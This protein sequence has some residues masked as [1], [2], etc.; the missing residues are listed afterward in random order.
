MT[1][2][3]LKDKVTGDKFYP[4]T[5]EDAVIDNNG[6]LLSSKLSNLQPLVISISENDTT[7]PSGTYASI[8]AALAA[9]REVFV[10][11]NDDLLTLP[12]VFSFPN[13][14]YVFSIGIAIE[15]SSSVYGAR[16]MA[17]DTV[18]VN[19]NNVAP[20]EHDH[21]NIANGGTLQT[22]DIAIANGDK[23]VVTDASDSNKIART[24][25]AFDGST[26]TKALSQKGTFETFYQKP[27][28]GIPE[29]HLA[30]AVQETLDNSAQKRKVVTG[31]VSTTANGDSMYMT[32][33]VFS[34]YPGETI[35]FT[36]TSNNHSTCLES[37]PL[38]AS[39]ATSNSGDVEWTNNT[40]DLVDVK[41]GCAS[42][43]HSY[44]VFTYCNGVP[45]D[46]LRTDVQASLSKADTAIQSIKTLN[47]K[48]LLGS[49]DLEVPI[50]LQEK[51]FSAFTA[52]A[53]NKDNSYVFF[54]NVVPT[55]NNFYDNWKIR[56]RLFVTT[57]ED[58]TQGV[59]ECE[60][61]SAGTN[62]V[63]TVNNRFYST[64]YLPI[65][66]HLLLW[67]STSA[68]YD[69]RATYPMK[70]GVRLLNA[71]NNTTLARTFK[72]QILETYNCTTSF[73]TNIET[74]GSVNDD[75]LY[76]SCSE[77][78]AS[79]LGTKMVGDTNYP[80]YYYYEYYQSYR[81]HSVDT[82]LYRYKFCGFDRSG[83]LIPISSTN[84]TSTMVEKIPSALG[85]DVSRGLVFY[86]SSAIITDPTVI[87]G[88]GTIHRH[89]SNQVIA[90]A[91]Y[92]FNTAISENCEIY[93][94][95]TY[96][97]GYFTL[98]DNAT[99]HNLYYLYVTNGG[100]YQQYLSQFTSGYYYWLLGNASPSS[101]IDFLPDH[102]LYY[103]DGTDLIPVIGGGSNDSS[104]DSSNDSQSVFYID[105]SDE[106]SSCPSGTYN[107][108]TDAIAAG[109]LPVLRITMDTDE[110]QTEYFYLT[111]DYSIGNSNEECYYVFSNITNYQ[112]I[113]SKVLY[114][115][116]S[117]SDNYSLTGQILTST[118]YAEP[119]MQI[120]PTN[121]TAMGGITAQPN[122]YY[123]ISDNPATLS[124]KLP[125]TLN[126]T[127]SEKIMFQF[128]TA[129]SG[130]INISFNIASGEVIAPSLY[131]DRDLSWESST[132]YEVTAIHNG[133]SWFIH[134]HVMGMYV[135]K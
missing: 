92:T 9:G 133:S 14:L 52:S 31:T 58:W 20:D 21:G 99:N 10:K 84:Q 112:D 28:S 110:G 59:Y 61:G 38:G 43:G 11:V 109:M 5:H 94:A 32:T 48:S 81:I 118:T 113:N 12:L 46:E 23:L 27:Y 124:I 104:D 103:Y 49:G 53:N 86:N 45:K 131:V 17:D 3:W 68:K 102:P 100:T 2:D 35:H 73:T 65:Y 105:I 106:D 60:W 55:S 4:I 29:N 18:K 111:D 8:T 75:N 83:R 87:L 6:T 132:N 44:T 97:N 70:I 16:I 125:R 15:T 128:V 123:V 127:F 98:A 121:S 47:G 117:D 19:F 50:I 57:S 122:K 93:L 79:Q 120:V 62:Q 134:Q 82:P 71:R 33:E 116:I 108:I 135:I 42:S 78:T 22:N 24:S 114:C 36:C 85:M 91:N 107:F 69:N 88:T 25:L 37:Y 51:T 1:K 72:I 34:V 40:N 74:Y 119:K 63:H 76:G 95:G 67:Y 89:F 130:K 13:V 101:G 56:Y 77:A 66:T 96:S 90:N 80:N 115:T 30:V 54:M 39:L 7:V 26:T 41:G 126:S 64:T 129:N